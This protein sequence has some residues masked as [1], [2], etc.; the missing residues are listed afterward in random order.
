MLTSTHD[1]NKVPQL[2]GAQQRYSSHVCSSCLASA[3]IVVSSQCMSVCSASLAGLDMSRNCA[4][5]AASAFVSSAVPSQ[6]MMLPSAHSS[7]PLP[8]PPAAHFIPFNASQPSAQPTLVHLSRPGLAS[9][10]SA[11][12]TCTVIVSRQQQQQQQHAGFP[13]EHASF[14]AALSGFPQPAST[15]Q[16]AAAVLA[17]QAP[18]T[19]TAGKPGKKSSKA[20][21]TASRAADAVAGMGVLSGP[22][23]KPGDGSAAAPVRRKR[24]PYKKRVKVEG[25]QKAPTGRKKKAI[26]LLPAVE[27]FRLHGQQQ[28]QQQQQAA[29]SQQQTAYLGSHQQ[30]R[31]SKRARSAPCHPPCIQA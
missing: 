11:D 6:V 19:A 27:A 20:S 17:Q 26:S 30:Q 5:A 21:K 12:S 7:Y 25:E 23:L 1:C 22:G 3:P 10:Q 16:T 18:A 29:G 28:Q 2:H 4:S 14:S 31:P 8:P 24:G 13:L 15:L 9:Q